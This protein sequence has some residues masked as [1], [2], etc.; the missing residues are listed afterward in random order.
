MFLRPLV[1]III[2]CF[3]SEDYVA[4]AIQSALVQNYPHCEVIVVDDGSL[5]RSL[6]VIKSFDS[7]I[8]WESGP[9]RGGCSARNRGMQMAR[10]AFIQFLDA[11][12]ILHPE[13]IQILLEGLNFHPEAQFAWAAYLKFE[14]NEVPQCLKSACTKHSV[15]FNP[16]VSPLEAAYAPWASL[17]RVEFLMQVGPWDESL[18][19]WVDLEYHARIAACCTSYVKTQIPLYGYRN[20]SGDRI[21]NS[22]RK[23]TNLH[24]AYES[25]HKTAA[26][27]GA[28]NISVD[29][30]N[31]YL[32]PFYV[33]LARSAAAKGDRA[34][35]AECLQ[36]AVSL[37]QRRD[38]HRKAS[39]VRVA[40]RLLGLRWTSM[41]IE[42][43]LPPI[44]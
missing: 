11:D 16:S 1:S 37:T 39:L 12:D 36:R 34:M 13:R 22:N 19:R 23:H 24:E 42:R 2:P 25:L 44:S 14:E 21:S 32:F 6:E 9:N 43:A 35:F 41:L 38:F 40:S 20:H 28:S 31:F 10:G 3:N 33:Q 29:E 4:E 8:R 18:R 27:L 7:R 15:A 30:L 17:F 26:A 5:D